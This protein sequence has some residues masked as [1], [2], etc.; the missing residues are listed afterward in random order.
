MNTFESAGVLIGFA[1]NMEGECIP[2]V[3]AYEHINGK[4]V[5]DI[6]EMVVTEGVIILEEE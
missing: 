1:V 4:L 6:G 2:K 3:V 5:E